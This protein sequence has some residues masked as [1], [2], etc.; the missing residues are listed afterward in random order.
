MNQVKIKNVIQEYS[1]GLRKI[2]G[3]QLLDVLLYGSFARGEGREDSDIDIVCVLRSPFDYNE[4][5]QRSSQLTANLSL[6]NDVV[7]SRVFA[8]EEELRTRNLP[9]FMN[10]RSE[11]VPA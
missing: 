5:M 8:S 9:L 6:E 2:F 7:L 1:Q 11:S 10:I 3:D 4:A